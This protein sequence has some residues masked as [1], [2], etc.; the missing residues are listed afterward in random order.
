MIEAGLTPAHTHALKPLLN[1]PFAGTFHEPTANRP[2]VS[3][4]PGI[5]EMCLMGSEIVL[6][7]GE[8]LSCRL[9]QGWRGEQRLQ[10]GRNPPLATVAQVMSPAP[11]GLLTALRAAIESG[12]GAFIGECKL[13]CVNAHSREHCRAIGKKES[14]NECTLW[15]S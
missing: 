3:L 8:G 9:G 1:K 2:A 6:Q 10:L 5:I 14:M 7:I 11:K 15:K 13:N 12:F 4:E